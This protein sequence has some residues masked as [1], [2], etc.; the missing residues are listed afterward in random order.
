MSGDSIAR[1][2]LGEFVVEAFYDCVDDNKIEI[3]T[4]YSKFVCSSTFKLI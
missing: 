3:Y 4:D 1:Q 2:M